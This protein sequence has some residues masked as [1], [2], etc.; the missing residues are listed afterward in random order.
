MSGAII[1]RSSVAGDAHELD[2]RGDWL[3]SEH[4]GV[5]ER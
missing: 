5:K 1:D 2:E 4:V 3:A